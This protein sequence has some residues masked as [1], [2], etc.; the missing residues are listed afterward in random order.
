MGMYGYLRRIAPSDVP[1]I[2]DDPRL[3]EAF[4]FGER[5]QVVEERV[6]GLLGLFL[7]LARIKVQT[8]APVQTSK[9]PLW[10][11]PELGEMIGL[12]KAWHGLHFLL[13]GTDDGGREPACFLL[14]GGEDLGDEDDDGFQAR[15]LSAEQVRWFGEHLASLSTDE[16]TRRFDPDRMTELRIYPDV[17]WKRPEE[18]DEPRGYLLAAFTELREFI[19]SAAARSDAVVV[20]IS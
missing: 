15:L 13:T 4:L 9:D 14:S 18:E 6:P 1:R 5:T 16:L 20:C 7:R 11:L 19:T 3:L 2:R 12:D 8:A 10:P 17:I